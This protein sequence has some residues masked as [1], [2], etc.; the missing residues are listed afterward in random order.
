MANTYIQIGSTVT[1][2]ALGAATIDFSSIP[3]SYTDLI[4]K[5]ST[6]DTAV[7]ANTG[8]AKVTF[9]GTVTTYTNKNVTGSGSAA[10]SGSAGTSFI[11]AGLGSVMPTVGNTSSTFSN[12]EIYIPNYAGSLNKQVSTDAVGENNATAAYAG[13]VATLLANTA[14]VASIT[15][16]STTLF[17]QYSTAS[18][19]GILKS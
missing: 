14:A 16:T 13:I 18:L 3:S 10:A 5:L 6:R 2:G 9:N 4:V 19:Y 7:T 8:A 11:D 1:V 15:I 17:G 12:I